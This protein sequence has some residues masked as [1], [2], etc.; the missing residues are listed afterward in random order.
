MST[1]HRSALSRPRVHTSVTA[2]IG[3]RI[4]GGEVKPGETLPNEMALCEQYGVSRSAIR[5]TLRVLTAK[6]LIVARSR[7]GT[8]VREI[9]HWNLLDEDILDWAVP[10]ALLD[11]VI[12]S[13]IEARL[14]IEPEAARLA[15][16]RATSEQIARIGEAV[17]AM[18]STSEAAE[19]HLEA[20]L[21]FH[22]G[23]IAASQNIV[24]E[25]FLAVI[26]RG[27]LES[28][29][30]T[31]PGAKDRKDAAQS[32]RAV[33]DAIAAGDEAGAHAAMVALLSK[34]RMN[35]KAT[36]PT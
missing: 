13:L 22:A 24:F 20:D 1:A 9:E 15:A 34:A 32:H 16:K 11:R 29:N 25:Q 6:G 12:T 19:A 4:V 17:D 36:R 14:A 3:A 7:V 21:A 10:G 31:S 8:S 27:L 35:L 23:V 18:A 30:R 28:F 2:E 5:E 26:R 33:Y